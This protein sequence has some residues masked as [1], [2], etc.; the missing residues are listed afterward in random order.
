MADLSKMV[1]RLGD[2]VQ[3]S[4]DLYKFTPTQLEAEITEALLIYNSDYTIGTLPPGEEHL[5]MWKAMS[6][7]YFILASKHAENIRFRVQND[8]YHG[9][10][11]TPNYLRLAEKYESLFNEN[12]S[13]QVNTVTRRQTGTGLKAPYYSGDTP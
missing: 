13:I 9:Q 1:T 8:E 10:Q 2:K 7:C 6:S 4:D 5:V 12:R 11:A 3:P